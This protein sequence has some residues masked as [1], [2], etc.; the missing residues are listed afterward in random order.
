MPF[1]SNLHTHSIYSD[2]GN[3]PEEYVQAAIARGFVSIGFSEHA[4]GDECEIPEE[5]M[6]EYLAEIAALKQK[7]SG[8]IEIYTGLELD[9][10]APARAWRD[11]LDF[12]IGSVHSIS[13][14][15][16][17]RLSVDYL[18]EHMAKLVCIY[19]SDGLV[20]EY[21]RLVREVL[22][23][24]PD[25]VAHLDLIEKLNAENRFFNPVARYYEQAAEETIAAISQAKLVVEVNTGAISRGYTTVPYPSKK[26]LQI[27]HSY[28]VPMTISSD[29]HSADA[30]DCA[31]DLA[32]S[33]LREV[34][35]KNVM[36]FRGG[37]FVEVA[38]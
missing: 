4:P 33:L 10:L 19:G 9:Y 38:I 16:G 28:K 7:Y 21:Y 32:L 26:L 37:K 8:Q 13:T 20:K 3:A 2:G 11:S 1:L 24:K 30:I 5:K 23:E 6:P 22:K 29:A 14:I 34:G 31:F 27:L 15:D 35:Y 36:L 18:P 12:T 25:I 17:E